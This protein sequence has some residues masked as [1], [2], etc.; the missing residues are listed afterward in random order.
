MM[1]NKVLQVRSMS[2]W[3]PLCIGPYSQAN[4]IFDTFVYIAGAYVIICVDPHQI[5]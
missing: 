2:E 5:S 3:A 4:T 1:Y